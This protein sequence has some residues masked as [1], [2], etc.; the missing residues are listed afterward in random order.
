[1]PT[2]ESTPVQEEPVTT[3]EQEL[4]PIGTCTAIYSFEAQESDE[5]SIEEGVTIEV[6]GTGYL[7][8]S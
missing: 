5:L 7:L 1:M 3:P 8:F 4:A 6:L 2:P